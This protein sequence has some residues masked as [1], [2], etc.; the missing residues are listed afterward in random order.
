M[1]NSFRKLLN[2]LPLA[3]L[4]LATANASAQSLPANDRHGLGLG[5]TPVLEF[6]LQYQA[7]RVNAPPAQ[8][9]CFWMQGGGLQLA[10]TVHPRWSVVADLSG[11][12]ATNVNGVE[13]R[14]STFNYVFGPRFSLRTHRAL[15]PYLQGLAGASEVFSNYALYGHGHNSFAAMGG[16]GVE[17]RLSDHLSLV[18]LEA[19]YIYSRAPNGDNSHQNNLRIGAGINFRLGER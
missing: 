5:Q 1:T 3:L 4:T 9:G 7:T 2:L 16:G 13:Q 17:F 15:T 14:L 10:F 18:P 8:C 11:A 6:G 19:N 12:N